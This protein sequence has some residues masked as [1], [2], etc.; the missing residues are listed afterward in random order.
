MGVGGNQTRSSAALSPLHRGAR[1]PHGIGCTAGSPLRLS[2]R[3]HSFFQYFF[4]I[5]YSVT[6]SVFIIRISNDFLLSFASFYVLPYARAIVLARARAVPA[7]EEILEPSLTHP[8]GAEGD[9]KA[10]P[11]EAVRKIKETVLV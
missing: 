5:L 2:R 3:L 1:R 4:C 7:G 10:Q 9:L 6:Y 8:R 11:G